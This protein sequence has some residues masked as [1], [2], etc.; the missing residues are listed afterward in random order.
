MVMLPLKGN[1]FI[2]NNITTMITNY[3]KQTLKDVFNIL[4]YCNTNGIMVEWFKTIDDFIEVLW[5]NEDIN[6]KLN[7]IVLWWT[8][9]YIKNIEFRLCIEQ[10]M[11]R[12][13]ML[14]WIKIEKEQLDEHINSEKQKLF[15][16][17]LIIRTEEELEQIE[18]EKLNNAINEVNNE[19]ENN[20]KNTWIGKLI[21]IDDNIEDDTDYND[22]TWKW[23]DEQGN[24][25]V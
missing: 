25:I 5:N 7:K 1:L 9:N 10:L 24:E 20:L 17:H 12:S 21:S 15:N 6:Q 23:Y 13:W 4:W 8:S 22:Y 19:T 14:N 11:V 18:K 3:T 2:L 16:N